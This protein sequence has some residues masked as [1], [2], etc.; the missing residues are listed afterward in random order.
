MQKNQV[1][2][3]VWLQKIYMTCWWHSADLTY[4]C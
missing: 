1:C 2:Y 4:L 3:L